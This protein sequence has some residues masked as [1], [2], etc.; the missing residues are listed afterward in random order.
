MKQYFFYIIESEVLKL[1]SPSS[2]P[3][4]RLEIETFRYKN[5][6]SINLGS[7][8]IVGIGIQTDTQTQRHRD[9]REK[10]NWSK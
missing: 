10:N 4:F 2:N 3:F 6:L 9:K 5:E 8:V 1:E 7:L